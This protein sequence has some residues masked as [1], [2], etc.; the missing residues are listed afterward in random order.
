MSS[1][2][3]GFGLGISLILAIGAQNAFVLKQGL[4]K[5]YV[6]WVCLICS[7]SDALLILMGVTGFSSIIKSYPVVADVARY[8][9]ALFL[10]V[11]GAMNFYSA[12]QK[13]SALNPKG[14]DKQS[15]FKV[16]AVCL[17]F[18][19]L[20]PH[21]YLDTVF[22]IGAVSVKFSETI[23]YFA[24]GAVASS[25]VFFFTLGF[26]ARLLLPIFEKP[27]AWRVL[28]CIIGII[29]WMIAVSLLVF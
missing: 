15:L 7:L 20:N 21:V 24:V 23:Q 25:F 2:F 18:T 26:G 3:S 5:Q 13:T 29:M 12:Y 27:S 16:I 28:D 17:A 4:K 1:F 6:F 14:E 19:W 10:F 9:G 22:L 11:Y 8:T